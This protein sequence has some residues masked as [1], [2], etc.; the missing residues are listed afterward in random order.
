M[1]QLV[2][3]FMEQYLLNNEER[4]EFKQEPLSHSEYLDMY[5][6]MNNL[7]EREIQILKYTFKEPDAS[8]N[9]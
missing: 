5:A 7:S 3:N 8:S 1:T 9:N 4:R 2:Q 6:T